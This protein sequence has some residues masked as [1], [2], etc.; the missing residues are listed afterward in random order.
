M[1]MLDASTRLTSHDN[2]T[3]RPIF[4]NNAFMIVQGFKTSEDAGLNNGLN[5]TASGAP[6]ELKLDFD[7]QANDIAMFAFVQSAYNLNI[8]NGGNVSMTDGRV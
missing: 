7:S 5:T 4:E 6:L 2:N 8:F 1:D 3:Y